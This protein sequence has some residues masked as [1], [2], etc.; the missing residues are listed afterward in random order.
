MPPSAI[1]AR[2]AFT[3]SSAFNAPARLYDL[4]FVTGPFYHTLAY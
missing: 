3:Q 4:R 2:A 1:T